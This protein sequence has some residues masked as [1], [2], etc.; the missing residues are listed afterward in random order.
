EK[1]LAAYP[2]GLSLAT[3]AARRCAA[4]TDCKLPYV[5]AD[6]FVSAASRPPLYHEVLQLPERDRDL[7]KLLQIDVNE[8]IRQERVARAG[9]NGSGLSRNNRLIERHESAHGAY[10]K[11]YDF[12]GSVGKQNLFESPLGPGGPNGFQHDGGEIIFNLPNGLQAY[13]LVD[14]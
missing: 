5:R 1:I 2:Y 12:A 4:A 6:W 3:P 7:E 8:N 10:W 9:F 11:S 14:A 13:M